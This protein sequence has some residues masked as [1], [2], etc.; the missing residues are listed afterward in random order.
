MLVKN[1][2]NLPLSIFSCSSPVPLPPHSKSA[3]ARA[4]LDIWLRRW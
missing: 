3:G 1:A 4:L 2:S